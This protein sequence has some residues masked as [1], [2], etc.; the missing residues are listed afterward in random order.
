M[1]CI[2]P[3]DVTGVCICG[4]SHGHI[5]L[6][7][8]DVYVFLYGVSWKSG[9]TGERGQQAGPFVSSADTEVSLL[10]LSLRSNSM[11]PLKSLVL[12]EQHRNLRG[13][14]PLVRRGQVSCRRSQSLFT[15]DA[16][17]A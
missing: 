14:M 9:L 13:V 1:F 16:A 7:K 3:T 10:A 5:A 12:S 17:A 15:E 8:Q 2:P 4:C 11:A 6:C